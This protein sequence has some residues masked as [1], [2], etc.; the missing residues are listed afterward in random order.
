MLQSETRKL[1]ASMCTDSVGVSRQ[2]GSDEARLAM[3]RKPP[4]DEGRAIDRPNLRAE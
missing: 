3:P 1:A 2:I 4:P